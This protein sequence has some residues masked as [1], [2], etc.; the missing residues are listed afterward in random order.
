LHDVRVSKPS[1][2]PKDKPQITFE[3][4]RYV[5]AGYRYSLCETL[6]IV[7]LAI[8]DLNNIRE[9]YAKITNAARTEQRRQEIKNTP[10][11]H[12]E[13]SILDDDGASF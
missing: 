4:G 6:A 5:I 3:D 9:A 11:R 1:V 8:P 12:N 13:V 2:K 7:N 10:G